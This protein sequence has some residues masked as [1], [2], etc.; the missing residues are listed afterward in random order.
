MHLDI[1][2]IYQSSCPVHGVVLSKV[3]GYASTENITDDELSV[4]DPQLY[5]RIWDP[6]DIVYP[7][8]GG[9]GE[10]GSFTVVT[11]LII[12]PNQT[13]SICAEVLSKHMA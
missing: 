10:T 8:Q 6:A 1:R 5:R 7:A 3:K 12:S 4:E 2:K 13:L 11:N 9:E